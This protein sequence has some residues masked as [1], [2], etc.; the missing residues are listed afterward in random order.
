MSNVICGRKNC[1]KCGRWRHAFDFGRKPHGLQSWCKACQREAAR[2]REGLKRRGR[3]YEARRRIKTAHLPRIPG[4]WEPAPTTP[5]YRAYQRERY[6]NLTARQRQDR[7]EYQRIF[8]E[9]RRRAAG[10]PRRN[11][12]EQR[13]KQGY[14]EALILDAAPFREWLLTRQI[15][16]SWREWCSVH[17]IDDSLCREIRVGNKT[18][19]H[20]DTVDKVLQIAGYHLDELYPYE[21]AAA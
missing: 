13:V 16:T 7:R 15:E 1:T 12:K 19:V 3:P 9:G 17:E 18:G 6:R 2:V 10:I 4:S 8:Q 21:E 14:D 5:E 11:L 20:V